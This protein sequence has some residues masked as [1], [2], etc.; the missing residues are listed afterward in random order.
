[1]S[2]LDLIST[3]ITAGTVI[4]MLSQPAIIVGK[5]VGSGINTVI[6]GP[7]YSG[8]LNNLFIDS[9]SLGPIAIGMAE[10]NFDI[11]D[12][13]IIKT[14]LYNLHS[15]P[16]NGLPNSGWCSDQGR[17][18]GDVEKA[19]QGCLE[20]TKSRLSRLV[21]RFKQNGVDPE[22]DTEALINSLDMWNQASPNVSD[23][24]VDRY[25]ELRKTKGVLEAIKIARVEAFKTENN[26][27]SAKGL[28]R[29]CSNPKN[30]AYSGLNIYG[31]G[32]EKWKWECIAMDQ[33]RRVQ[34]INKALVFS[35]SE[36]SK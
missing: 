24:Y 18:G 8:P 36:Q 4:T 10:G 11:K 25:S 12:N 22:K 26:K 31:V 16:A 3:V 28:E 13:Q 9:K 34:A 7:T 20:R 35:V 33:N 14:H 19:D 23:N 1:M 2:K 6:N 15:D 5:A 29:I 21:N 17:G 27:L 30:T 32:T